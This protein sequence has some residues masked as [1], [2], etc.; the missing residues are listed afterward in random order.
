MSRF[1][2]SLTALAVMVGILM[3]VDALAKPSTRHHKRQRQHKSMK[4]SEKKAAPEYTSFLNIH[5][6]QRCAATGKL[7]D[8]KFS[9]TYRD[10]ENRTYGHIWV[11][12]ESCKA[13]L[14]DRLPE[15]YERFHRTVAKTGKKRETLP[16]FVNT[17]CPVTV[18]G[19]MEAIEEDFPIEF[20]GM[21]IHLCSPECVEAF[22]KEPERP[23][24]RLDRMGR[25]V[26]PVQRTL[27][28][29]EVLKKV[30]KAGEQ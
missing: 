16:D 21:V 5:S 2:F 28:E 25:L 9:M 1:L 24:R 19:Q 26:K 7:V 27:E 11:C 15:L 29:V 6:N 22:L 13:E 17:I 12:S 23:L 18:D 20:N 14:K 10:E 4:G 30:K 3:P 8:H